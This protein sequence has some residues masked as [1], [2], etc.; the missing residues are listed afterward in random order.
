MTKHHEQHQRQTEIED[1]FPARD[2]E[3]IPKSSGAS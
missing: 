3:L 2:H 1:F